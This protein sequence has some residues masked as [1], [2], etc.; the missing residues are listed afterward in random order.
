MSSPLLT[1]TPK[2]QLTAEQPST[3]KCWN[4]PK[5]IPDIRRQG[6]SHNE[7]VGGYSQ[8]PYPTGGLP[9]NWKIIIPQ[10]FSHRSESPEPHIR[11][12][13]LGV[14]QREE[15]PPENLALKASGV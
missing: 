7:T 2:S 14:Q 10:K 9:K 12:P 4:L 1:K 6:R 13:S 8:I 11:L 15:E 5:K 3:E